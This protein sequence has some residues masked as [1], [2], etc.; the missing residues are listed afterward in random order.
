ML[1]AA[2]EIFLVVIGILIALQINTW[3]EQRKEAV[4]ELELLEGLL[5]DI[6]TNE[7]RLKTKIDQDS[8]VFTTNETLLR[9]I[10]DESFPYSDSLG[11]YFGSL[12]RYNTFFANRMAYET[13]K[14]KGFHTIKNAALRSEIIQLYDES[15]DISAHIIDQK[16]TFLNSFTSF[17]NER[18][19]I[20][21]GVGRTPNNFEALKKDQVFINTVSSITS[22]NGNT[23]NYFEMLLIWNAELKEAIEAE[24][25]RLKKT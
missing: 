8:A 20:K 15:Y 9:I 22:S 4:L 12:S 6:T 25:K 2:G 24:I 23:A 5:D 18:F 19:F 16:T 10:Q 3:N 17:L 1:Y 11:R 21:K 13:L 14:G 7:S